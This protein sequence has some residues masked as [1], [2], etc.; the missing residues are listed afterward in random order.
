MKKNFFAAALILS[1]GV[2]SFAA[3]SSDDVPVNP[4]E[5]KKTTTMMSIALKMP[6]ASG[7][8]GATDQPYN[9]IGEWLGQEKITGVEVFVFNGTTGGSTLEAHQTFAPTRV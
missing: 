2:G 1:L 3:C 5:Q 7:Q 8:R 9:Y 4:T 6:A